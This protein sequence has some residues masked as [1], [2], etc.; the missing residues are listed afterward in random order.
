MGSELH[1]GRDFYLMHLCDPAP[2][3]IPGSE[4]APH[5]PNTGFSYL[6]P[7]VESTQ[8]TTERSRKTQMTGVS[9]QWERH[10]ISPTRGLRCPAA[11]FPPDLWSF[12]SRYLILPVKYVKSHPPCLQDFSLFMPA[13]PPYCW[14]SAQS[15][16]FHFSLLSFP[17]YSIHILG[18]SW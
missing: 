7:K 1:M 14:S 13:S 11:A 6:R 15:S 9:I 12:F 5:I 8:I 18:L 4:E 2:E 3:K 10:F 16:P 17:L